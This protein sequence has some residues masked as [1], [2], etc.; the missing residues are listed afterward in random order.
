MKLLFFDLE[1]TGLD[2]KIHGIH[3]LSGKIV[4]GGVVKEAFDFKVK[5]HAN[6]LIDPGA[7][8]VAKVSEAQVLAYPPMNRVFANFKTVLN[9]YVSPYDTIDKFHLVGYNN[10]GF[11][12]NF[13]RAWFEVNGDKY[14]GSYFWSDSIDVLCLASNHLR[15][16]RP[17]MANFKLRTVAEKMGITV[18]NEKLHDAMYDIELTHQIYDLICAPVELPSDLHDRFPEQIGTL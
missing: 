18:D 13:L 9:R 3:Q 2:H 15:P 6:A 1:T 10:A 7:L 17:S 14:F 12:N 16:V 11:D 4:V 8:S 5:P